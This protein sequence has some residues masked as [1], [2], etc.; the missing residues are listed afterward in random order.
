LLLVDGLLYES[1]GHE[2][3][4]RSSLSSVREVEPETGEI[5]KQVDLNEDLFGE[6]LA[7]VGDQIVQLTWTDG[8]R[9]LYDA[10]TLDPVGTQPYED[11]G[12]GMCY[13]GEHIYTSN[14]STEITERDPETFAVI[15]KH[16]VTVLGQPINQINELECV[17]DVIYANVWYTE[18]I[19]RI[20]KA[21]GVVTG[22]IDA[23]GMLT[24]EQRAQLT[25][26]GATM[27]GIA[28][29][30]ADDTFLLTGKLWPWM[31]RVEFVPA[32][33]AA[34]TAEAAEAASG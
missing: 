8:I 17:G 12:W 3:G 21:T 28:Y 23:S 33:D 4:G 11:E 2:S 31:F 6:G 13:D 30:A 7:L 9:I 18:S 29:D 10:E 25:Y 5:L 22:L 24:P 19:L 15:A 20:D 1:T 34:A 26:S 27:N 14:G 32:D 16:E